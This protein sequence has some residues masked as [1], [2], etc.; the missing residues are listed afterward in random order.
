M[1]QS[2][3][4]QNHLG[5]PNPCHMYPG[6]C[7]TQDG[8]PGD[9]VDEDGRHVDHGSDVRFVPGLEIPGD[10]DPEI[11]AQ[12]THLSAGKPPHIGF[13]GHD[14]TPEQA[15]TKAHELRQ[16]ADELDVLADK[17]AVAQTL[18]DVRTVRETASPAFAGILAIVEN[19]IVRDGADPAEVFE[20]VLQLMNQARAEEN[21]AAERAARRSVDRAFPV[22]AAFLADER[23]RGEHQ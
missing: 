14:L 6:L 16:F 2:A 20:R 15:R 1:Q 10:G 23:A 11:W 21:E 7:T 9:V 17:V 13:M 8:E 3:I 4:H 19:A 18:H 12:F 22:V 5:K